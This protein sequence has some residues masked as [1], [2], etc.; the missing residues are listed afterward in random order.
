MN[1]KLWLQLDLHRVAICAESK[2]ALV[3]D[4]ATGSISLACVF[5]KILRSSCAKL[6][7][8]SQL[9]K[10][11]HVCHY[12]V[13]LEPFLYSQVHNSD[14]SISLYVREI[15]A[16]DS[17]MWKCWYA[18]RSRDISHYENNHHSLHGWIERPPRATSTM[19]TISFAY[20]L[21]HSGASRTWLPADVTWC[22]GRHHFLFQLWFGPDS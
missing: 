3:I 6:Q 8:Q 17:G 20:L 9:L 2:E 22:V 13:F 18:A 19:T 5:Y 21:T 16:C 1:R 4:R 12:L 15:F 7:I 10:I 11:H 14:W